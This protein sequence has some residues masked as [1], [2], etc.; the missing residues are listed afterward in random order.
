MA[1]GGSVVPADSAEIQKVVFALIDAETEKEKEERVRDQL[2]ISLYGIGTKHPQSVLPALLAYRRQQTCTKLQKVM[3]A[4][5]LDSILNHDNVLTAVDEKTAIEIIA[6]AVD[7]L[8]DKDLVILGSDLLVTVS[9]Q[10]CIEV[11]KQMLNL[12]QPGNLPSVTTFQTFGRIFSANVNDSIPFLSAV[13]SMLA[14]LLPEARTDQLKRAIAGAVAQFADAILE[15]VA[16]ENE[17]PDQSVKVHFFQNDFGV[18]YEY[19]LLHWLPKMREPEL[20]AFMVHATSCIARVISK[21]K[22]QETADRLLGSAVSVVRKHPH[23]SSASE[24]L[25][26]VLEMLSSNAKSILEPQLDALL[27]VIFAQACAPADYAKPFAVKS[28]NEVLRCFAILYLN[29]PDR[30]INFLLAKL[31]PNVVK[32]TVIK[33][34]SDRSVVGA[35]TIVNKLVNQ[36]DVSFSFYLN[37]LLKS[38]EPIIAPTPPVTLSNNVKQIL[39]QLVLT[40]ADRLYLTVD[41]SAPLIEF[42][43]RQ[44]SIPATTIPRSPSGLE[45]VTDEA[46]RAACEN[47]LHLLTTTVHGM[48]TILL[49]GLFDYLVMWQY[50]ESARTVAKCLVHLNT[51]RD[52]FATLA[53]SGAVK[54][55]PA[56]VELFTRLFVLSGSAIDQS[57]GDSLLR[58]LQLVVGR[59]AEALKELWEGT[60]TELENFFT[61]RASNE[62]GETAWDGQAWEESL[63]KLLQT[64]LHDLKNVEPELIH[65]IAECFTIQIPLYID[66]PEDKAFL[67]RALGTTLEIST[68]S[69]V[70]NKGLDGIFN[71]VNHSK[72]VERQACAV[73]VGKASSA[74]FDLILSKLDGFTV[75]DKQG[76]RSSIFNLFG[77]AKESKQESVDSERS[78]STIV[79][80]YGYAVS[81]APRALLLT[82][83]D[84]IMRSIMPF[85]VGVKE[86]AI[87]HSLCRF[88]EMLAKAL[89]ETNSTL[90]KRQALMF[91]MKDFVKSEPPELRS[92]VRALAVTACAELAQLPPKI[93]MEEVEDALLLFCNSVFPLLPPRHDSSEGADA[94]NAA[95]LNYEVLWDATIKALSE[96]MVTVVKVYRNAEA[97][98]VLLRNLKPWLESDSDHERYH[99]LTMLHN[100]LTSDAVTENVIA[101]ILGMAMGLLAM[102][103]MDPDARCR[104]TALACGKRLA[105]ILSNGKS[106][107]QEWIEAGRQSW[108]KE[109]LSSHAAA[110]SIAGLFYGILEGDQLVKFVRQLYYQ[111]L[112]ERRAVTAAG[113]AAILQATL[114]NKW[115]PLKEQGPD[116]L[117]GLLFAL[118]TVRDPATKVGIEGCIK[119]IAEHDTEMVA[120]VLL[121]QPVPLLPSTAALWRSLGSVASFAPILLQHCLDT[122]RTTPCYSEVHIHA[123][124]ASLPILQSLAVLVELFQSSNNTDLL[125]ANFADLAPVLIVITAAMVGAQSSKP[126]QFAVSSEQTGA[127][128]EWKSV[129]KVVPSRFAVDALKQLLKNANSVVPISFEMIED[130]VMYAEG[131]HVTCKCIFQ[132]A[133]LDAKKVIAGL[134]PYLNSEIDA[135][136]AAAVAMY[137]AMLESK[138]PTDA[139]QVQEV[140]NHLATKNSDQALIVR[141]FCIRGMGSLAQ[142]GPK[143][144]NANADSILRVILAGLEDSAD[145]NMN[146]APIE[147]MKALNKLLPVI[148]RARIQEDLISISVRLRPSFESESPMI[149]SMAFSLF[150]QAATVAENES[151]RAAFTQEV[152][153]VLVILL[154]HLNDDNHEVS[155]A[156]KSVFKLL[157]PLLKSEALVTALSYPDGIAYSRLLK[158]ISSALGTDFAD[159]IPAY[160][161]HIIGYFRSE[162]PTMRANA[163]LL[164]G[165]LLAQVAAAGQPDTTTSHMAPAVIHLLSDKEPLVRQRAAEALGLIYQKSSHHV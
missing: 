24:G 81:G 13:L 69:L 10:F 89:R 48:E 25:A 164:A 17:A 146:S 66:F 49:P 2:L 158:L 47:V 46:L 119:A 71:S 77:S 155:T 120:R 79:T 32:S 157:L 130:P 18:I 134:V 4:T 53:P 163:V 28:H 141:V 91:H 39:A 42:I 113:V 116:I 82:R 139:G 152:H 160:L 142:F 22:L 93:T 58:L 121:N 64:S 3:I 135:Q 98:V 145:G 26:I 111:G 35:L 74:H 50:T 140:V 27:D 16:R 51:Q 132:S 75:P 90:D 80:C 99:S 23:E 96:F 94:A 123:R 65:R 84:D 143:I 83:I 129:Y 29:F 61:M 88:T 45:V 165:N 73:A 149:R 162:S 8:N 150:G 41:N 21:E 159:K 19:I 124:C 112:L 161:N 114:K 44:C 117:G 128:S 37:A 107:D 20:A 63:L 55:S 115:Q 110:T 59:M 102:R 38:L 118:K 67:Y 106:S 11:M 101:P 105:S 68:D 62:G 34:A 7:G 151:V 54:R 104:E 85:F 43:V 6:A 72:I 5:T 87:K 15:Y 133:E 33:D 86:F 30:I 40:L 56:V 95:Y 136:R 52:V 9:R 60:I 92:S 122:L 108:M 1:Q 131:L 153:D 137:S 36:P 126:P 148:D 97:T 31:S 154:L 12:F 147:A 14:P 100:V 138:K 76:K 103:S 144:V 156:T 70:V 78:K 109:S 125:Q 127:D 57:D